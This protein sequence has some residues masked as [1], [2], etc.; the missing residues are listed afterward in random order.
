M[1]YCGNDQIQNT[2][3]VGLFNK[4]I[5]FVI[6][7]KSIILILLKKFTNLFKNPSAIFKYYF[8]NQWNEPVCKVT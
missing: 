6:K 4:V 8:S 1:G 3:S 5:P 2:I 7:E